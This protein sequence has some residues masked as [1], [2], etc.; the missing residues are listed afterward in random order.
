MDHDDD[1][2]FLSSAVLYTPYT[3]R[4]HKKI[5]GAHKLRAMKPTKREGT[6]ATHPTIPYHTD[7]D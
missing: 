4:S 1:P 5:L 7:I 6:Q 2:A 3:V